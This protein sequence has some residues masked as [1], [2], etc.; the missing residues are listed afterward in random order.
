MLGQDRSFVVTDSAKP[1]HYTRLDFFDHH[2]MLALSHITLAPVRMLDI[3]I[4]YAYITTTEKGSDDRYSK[5]PSI[6][7]GR[8]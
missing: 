7:H 3:Y 1:A 8:R 5:V 4:G 6:W 2:R